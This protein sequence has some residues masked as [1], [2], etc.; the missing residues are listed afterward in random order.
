MLSY[1]N[2]TEFFKL[3]FNTA[4]QKQFFGICFIREKIVLT[5]SKYVASK[6]DLYKVCS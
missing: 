3:I 5:K 1:R 6:Y 2:I 4:D